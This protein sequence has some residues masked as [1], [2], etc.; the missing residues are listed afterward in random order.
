[1][2]AN[3]QLLTFIVDGEEY[4]VRNSQ[5]NASRTPASSSTTYTV[6]F[7]GIKLMKQPFSNENQR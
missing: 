1:M 3:E 7:F 4:G 5:A 6:P 2:S